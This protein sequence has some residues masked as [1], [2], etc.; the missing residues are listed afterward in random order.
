MLKVP[1]LLVKEAMVSLT[2]EFWEPVAKSTSR[3]SLISLPCN[4]DYFVS[5]K[6][7]HQTILP[8]GGCVWADLICMNQGEVHCLVVHVRP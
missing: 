4:K 2:R 3:A 7:K 6:I 5:R 8:G 1:H